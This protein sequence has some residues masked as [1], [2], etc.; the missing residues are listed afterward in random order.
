MAC[1]ALDRTKIRLTTLVGGIWPLRCGRRQ[2]DAHVGVYAELY[3]FV[4]YL[5]RSG[6]GRRLE[7]KWQEGG[8]QTVLDARRV[9][10]VSVGLLKRGHRVVTSQSGLH[11]GKD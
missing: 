8:F 9:L 6:R 1:E 2:T 3:R 7:L 11:L 5:C 10:Q 4:S